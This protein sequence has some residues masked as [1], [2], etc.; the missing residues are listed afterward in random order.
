MLDAHLQRTQAQQE[1]F[2][3]RLQQLQRQRDAARQKA[4][5]I[6]DF[7]AAFGPLLQDLQRQLEPI[8]QIAPELLP[9]IEALLIETLA[10]SAD[11]VPLLQENPQPRAETPTASAELVEEAQAVEATI[12]AAEVEELLSF[13]TGP[14]NDRRR[15]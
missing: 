5:V 13:R 4:K 15:L 8:R 10:G 1:I 9:E 3:R 6:A 2:S 11:S 12:V 7:Q 14:R